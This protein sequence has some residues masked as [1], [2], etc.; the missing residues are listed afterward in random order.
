M[1]T[2]ENDH[3]WTKW[4]SCPTTAHHSGEQFHE[5]VDMEPG[6]Q[7]ARQRKSSWP[8]REGR[9]QVPTSSSSSQQK[10][11]R[12]FR[13][14]HNIVCFR[15]GLQAYH[16]AAIACSGKREGRHQ[17]QKRQVSGKTPASSSSSRQKCP[18]GFRRR[19][20]IVCFRGGLQAYH[21][22]AIAGSAEREGRRQPQKRQ[23]SDKI[24]ASPSSSRQKC[25]RGFRRRNN[26]V[27]ASGG[28]QASACSAKKEDRHQ[29][30][31]RRALEVLASSSSSHQ[32]CP[33][34]FR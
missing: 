10:Y 28:L 12:G 7:L 30:Q 32:K 21:E 29:F 6:G 34:G 18:R 9:K 33:R 1:P 24:P 22:A 25:L 8:K 17:P 27:C 4:Q 13:C 3:L 20:N 16:E 15:G 2:K 19:H 11:L 14:G 23:V 31:E 26:I 5:R